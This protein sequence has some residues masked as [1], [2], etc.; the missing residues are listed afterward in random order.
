[1]FFAY[2]CAKEKSTIVHVI[3]YPFS[4]VAQLTPKSLRTTV[5]KTTT[6]LTYTTNRVC[7]R[8]WCLDHFGPNYEE[9][10][11]SQKF[12]WVKKCRKSTFVNCRLLPLLNKISLTDR[13]WETERIVGRSPP[14][15]KIFLCLK[16]R[17]IYI[18]Q[19]AKAIWS[20]GGHIW[21][22]WPH[23]GSKNELSSESPFELPKRAILS[24]ME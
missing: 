3:F 12:F 14:H 11:S 20:H 1:M 6:T 13:S 15:A 2:C 7:R 8:R 23:F 24:K 10:N 18:I 17:F 19:F 21:L 9:K 4:L 22:F 16:W 5:P